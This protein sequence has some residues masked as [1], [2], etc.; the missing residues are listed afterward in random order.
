MFATEAIARETD[1][2][3]ANQSAKHFGDRVGYALITREAAIVFVSPAGEDLDGTPTPETR[4]EL[5]PGVGRA[6]LAREYVA[7]RYADR[8]AVRDALMNDAL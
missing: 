4:T 2:F 5:E 1:T 6:I 8:Y 7:V 3:L